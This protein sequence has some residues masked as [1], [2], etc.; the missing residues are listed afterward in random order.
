MA[1]A[2]SGR[3]LGRL[4]SVLR[5]IISRSRVMLQIAG[6]AG[7]LW[8]LHSLL[9]LLWL[10]PG[11]R[12]PWP[13]WM[14]ITLPD[15]AKRRFYVTDISQ[16]KALLEV[17]VDRDYDVPLDGEFSSIVDLGAN[18]GQSA[19][20]LRNRSRTPKSS[21]SKPIRWSPG[22]RN[23]TWP[24]IPITRWRRRRSPITTAPHRFTD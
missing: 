20:Y 21:P 11:Q 5:K 8:R 19:V 7:G 10:T 1:R 17:F 15:G 14:G 23:A 22:S 6:L 4:L 16:A 3:W 9:V 12:S 18:A 24:G 13:V 2:Q